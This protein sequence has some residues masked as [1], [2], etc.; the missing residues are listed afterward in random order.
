MDRFNPIPLV[1][2]SFGA[3]RRRSVVGRE[4]RDLIALFVLVVVPVAVGIG[5]FTLGWV[6]RDAGAL[7]SGFSLLA[8]SLLGAVSQFASW[9]QRLAERNKALDGVACRKIDEA[10]Y[11][12]LVAAVASVLLAG[13]SVVVANVALPPV[14]GDTSGVLIPVAARVLTAVLAVGGSYLVLTLILVINLFFDAY[15]DAY[16]LNKSEATAERE[17]KRWRDSGVM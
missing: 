7:I 9:R 2:A 8:G 12:A 5:S 17:A 6:L 1:I 11:N 10:V 15:R 4:P 3:L 16:G 13:L 14:S